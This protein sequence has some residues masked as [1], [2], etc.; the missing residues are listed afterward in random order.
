MEI[1]LHSSFLTLVNPNIA[2]SFKS[3][4]MNLESLEFIGR[5]NGER[6]KTDELIDNHQ[7]SGTRRDRQDPIR[8]AARSSGGAGSWLW[9][10]DS[11]SALGSFSCVPE[12]ASDQ[13]SSHPDLLPISSFLNERK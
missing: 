13:V 6:G 11:G 7:L 2:F 4:N 9:S 12:L 10:G 1:L 5:G 3:S 8:H